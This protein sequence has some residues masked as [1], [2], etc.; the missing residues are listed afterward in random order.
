MCSLKNMSVTGG[1][2]NIDFHMEKIFSGALLLGLIVCALTGNA[3]AVV[4]E[5]ARSAQDA[6]ALILGLLGGCAL[7]GGLLAMADESG[8]TA[9]LSRRMYP[10][11][12][13]LFSKNAA[14][15]PDT[16]RAVAAAFSANILGVG[17]AATPAGINAMKKLSGRDAD[18]FWLICASGLQLLPT[19]VI[20]MR[21]A[22][23]SGSPAAILPVTLA[24]T[25]VSSF[26]A[27][28]IRPRTK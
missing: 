28:L 22:A 7:W 26:A 5:M 1:L 25:A 11:L 9:W 16:M 3:S 4:P 15:S 10:L 21:A 13:K 14:S 20:A 23:G 24:S 6:V 12:K 2:C 19:T 8:L 27:Y 18:A 17:N